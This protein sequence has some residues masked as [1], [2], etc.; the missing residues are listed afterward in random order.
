MSC[1][2]SDHFLC[3]IFSGQKSAIYDTDSSVEVTS[4][5]CW[6]DTSYSIIVIGTVTAAVASNTI[7]VRCS[8]R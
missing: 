5:T 6:F 2:S 3:H 8:N 4:S 7:V 1:Y